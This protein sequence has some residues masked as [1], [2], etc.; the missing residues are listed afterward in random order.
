MA[1]RAKIASKLNIRLD[2]EL[3][4]QLEEA[5][6]KFGNSLQNEVVRRLKESF[7]PATVT[8]REKSLIQQTVQAVATAVVE[9]KF[10][11]VGAGAA[12]K[13]K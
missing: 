6:A 8:D 9:G 1:R 7:A 12:D 5:A 3:R 2:A 11:V 4:Q 10:Q 13:Q